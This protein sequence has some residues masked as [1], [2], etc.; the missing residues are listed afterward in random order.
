MTKT[1]REIGVGKDSIS[2]KVLDEISYF[3]SYLRNLNSSVRFLTIVLK[4]MCVPIDSI[5]IYQGKIGG[6]VTKKLKRASLIKQI[7]EAPDPGFQGPKPT[8]SVP[9]S[10]VRY[11]PIHQR[12]QK[13]Q[14]QALT[15]KSGNLPGPEKTCFCLRTRQN[16]QAVAVLQLRPTKYEK[17]GAPDPGFKDKD[18]PK[19]N[20]KAG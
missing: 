20:S 2:E 11:P 8:G 15:P 12:T 18:K 13:H 14:N 10:R 17:F 6:C 7:F 19:V 1:L 9:S 3:A 16:R 5:I 4:S